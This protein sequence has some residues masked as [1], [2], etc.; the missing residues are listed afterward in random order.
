MGNKP[1][2]QLLIVLGLVVIVV[3]LVTMRGW[4]AWF[5]HLPGDVRV[6]RP[7]VRIYVPIISMLLISILFSVLSY[8]LRR[9]F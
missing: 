7:N 6:E 5:G 9:L 1:L 4:L 2:G 3:G 8:V